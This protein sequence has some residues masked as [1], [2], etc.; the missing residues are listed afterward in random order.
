L[1]D[2]GE[3]S[4]SGCLSQVILLASFRLPPHDYVNLRNQAVGGSLFFGFF[5]LAKQ[6]KETRQ[7]RESDLFDTLDFYF[8]ELMDSSHFSSKETC[9]LSVGYLNLKASIPSITAFFLEGFRF[10]SESPL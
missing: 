9:G 3:F 8:N 7:S 6:K 2:D 1:H 5:L 4:A 10:N